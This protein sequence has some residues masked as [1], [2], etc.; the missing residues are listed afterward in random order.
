MRGCTAVLLVGLAFSVVAQAADSVVT[1]TGA[2]F[3]SIIQK[4]DFVVME[5]YATWCVQLF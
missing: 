3:D 4:N 1:A 5:F 2:N